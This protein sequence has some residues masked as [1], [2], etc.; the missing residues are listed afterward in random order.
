MSAD[1][2]D[3]ERAARHLLEPDVLAYLDLDERGEQDV[4][5][6]KSYREAV[7]I[8]FLCH[9]PNGTTTFCRDA[10]VE[11]TAGA[12]CPCKPFA[13]VGEHGMTLDEL[14]AELERCDA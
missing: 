5:A 9:D 13:L 12:G 6:R 7:E 3:D 8:G 1:P 14:F 11:H 10:P 2:F 4:V